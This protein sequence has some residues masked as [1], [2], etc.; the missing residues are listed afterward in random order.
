[1]PDYVITAK[2]NLY[3]RIPLKPYFWKEING[4]KIPSSFAFKTKPDEDGLSVNIA[5]LTT[6]KET[7]LDRKKFGVAEFS[8]KVPLELDYDCIY[9]P[10]PD[11]KAHALIAGDTNRIAK[12]L[13]FAAK[14][15][16]AD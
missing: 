6:I 7:I 4:K 15:V 16:F 1:M 2:D 11:N 14:Q 12:K 10:Q 13:S 9:D 8:A 3:R 5:A